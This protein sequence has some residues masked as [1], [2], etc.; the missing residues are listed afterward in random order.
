MSTKPAP[1]GPTKKPAMASASSLHRQAVASPPLGASG[2]SSPTASAVAEA[3][4]PAD[5]FD[6]AG[7]AWGDMGDMGEDD[8]AVNGEPIGLS[9]SH[10]VIIQIQQKISNCN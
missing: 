4:F 10:E 1:R 8:E 3:F 6:D 2:P 5:D 7:D 9:K